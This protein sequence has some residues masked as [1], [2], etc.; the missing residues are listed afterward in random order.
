M[1][2]GIFIL[3]LKNIESIPSHIYV[4]KKISYVCGICIY[5]W[6]YVHVCAHV[7]ARDCQLVSS[8]N[9]PTFLFETS[10]LLN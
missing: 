9:A 2:S 3:H 1:P 6:E 4:M 10:L 7:E 5:L 8:P